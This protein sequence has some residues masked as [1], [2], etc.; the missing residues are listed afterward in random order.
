MH[1]RRA[2]HPSSGVHKNGLGL[3]ETYACSCTPTVRAERRTARRHRRARSSPRRRSRRSPG[4]SPKIYRSEIFYAPPYSEGPLLPQ[5]STTTQTR[6]NKRR[7]WLHRRLRRET[8]RST[9]TTWRVRPAVARRS[10]KQS[11]KPQRRSHR[12]GRNPK[13]TPR[14]GRRPWRRTPLPRARSLHRRSGT[15]LG[16]PRANQVPPNPP[17]SSPATSAAS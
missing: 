7:R 1:A 5:R 8:S 16:R 14:R 3:F 9:W 2:G 13:A 6:R 10:E 12:Q 17:C 4:F 11:P 15:N